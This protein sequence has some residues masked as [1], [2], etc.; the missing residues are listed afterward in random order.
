M[1]GE[2][3]PDDDSQARAFASE[4]TGNGTVKSRE[5]LQNAS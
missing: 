1:A 2:V 4:T 5:R 3:S